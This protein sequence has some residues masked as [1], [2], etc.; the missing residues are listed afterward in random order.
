MKKT[1]FQSHKNSENKHHYS[2]NDFDLIRVLGR[3]TYG[4]VQLASCRL[5]GKLYALKSMKKKVIEESNNFDAVFN[6]RDVLFKFHHP[7]LVSARFCFQDEQNIFIVLDYV[8]GGDL[9]SFL[10]IKKKNSQ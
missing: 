3:G 7:F 5:D 9:S 6:E 10:I 1:D 8:G 4:K 2:I